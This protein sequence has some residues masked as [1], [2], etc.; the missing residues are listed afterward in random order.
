MVTH[1]LVSLQTGFEPKMPLPLTHLTSTD[2]SGKAP[3]LDLETIRCYVLSLL[4][5]QMTPA[6]TLCFLIM[7]L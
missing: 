4:F 3:R 1:K 6:L 5:L 2:G 7:Q